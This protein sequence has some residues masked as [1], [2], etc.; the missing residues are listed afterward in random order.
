MS[1]AGPMR[2]VFIKPGDC[3]SEYHQ[4]HDGNDTGELYDSGESVSESMVRA[5]EDQGV[6]LLIVSHGSRDSTEEV[7]GLSLAVLP[8]SRESGSIWLARLNKLRMELRVLGRLWQYR[9]HLVV[10]VAP[11]YRLFLAYLF[12][13]FTRTRLT[14]LVVDASAGKSGVLAR[15]N[16]FFFA[17]V[18]R[19]G[20]VR[21][22]LAC[23]NY[24]KSE[25]IAAGVAGSKVTVY[26]QSYGESF[27]SSTDAV[28]PARSGA[29]GRILLIGRLDIEHKGLDML[30][31]I[32]PRVLS[33]HK[34][35]HFLIIGD[36]PD[37]AKMEKAVADRQLQGSVILLGYRRQDE[38]FS[39]LRAADVL[40]L[41]S[42]HEGLAKVGLEAIFAGLPVVAFDCGG[43][44][45]YL[46]DGYNG[47]LIP[48]YD[49]DAF[50][51]AL[52]TIL[53]DEPLRLRLSANAARLGE[54][55]RHPKYT[56][57]L[58]VED[59]IR[60]AMQVV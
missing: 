32:A 31:D 38:L 41:P 5:C 12:T 18:L 56:L 45:D 54:E 36:G 4:F 7:D 28:E 47:F 24:L 52:V 58:A 6:S 30:L 10:A 9:P 39:Y 11:S 59:S 51:G 49:L 26:S 40:A 53:E 23:S 8:T 21:R 2:L 43:I 14:P 17:A 33:S 50:A 16:R 22:I 29:S 19:S 27:W 3:I 60:E 48:R 42:R 13:V 25:L 57:R 15:L 34:N 46:R 35:A 44:T 20:K 37:R 55:F 1:E